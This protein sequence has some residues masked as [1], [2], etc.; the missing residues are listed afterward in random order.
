MMIYLS[1]DD[2]QIPS[3]FSLFKI[4][5]FYKNLDLNS[6][7]CKYYGLTV[8]GFAVPTLTL[9]STLPLT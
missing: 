3:V 7:L 5:K 2:S 4:S 8:D 6:Q 9:N 1:Q